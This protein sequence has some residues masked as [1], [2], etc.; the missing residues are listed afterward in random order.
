[1]NPIL[2]YTLIAIIYVIGIFIALTII[3][4]INAD[5]TTIE[6]EEGVFLYQ[7]LAVFSWLLVAFS[8]LVCIGSCILSLIANIT[9][10]FNWYYDKMYRR[11]RK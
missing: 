11:F 7:G 2:I 4:A 3:A 1:M 10:P 9:K 6:S 5:D 8:L